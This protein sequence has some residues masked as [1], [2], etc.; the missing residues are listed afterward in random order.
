MKS[1]VL[2]AVMALWIVGCGSSKKGPPPSPKIKDAAVQLESS[3]ELDP[4]ANPNAVRGGRFTTWAGAFPKSL[5]QWLDYNSFSKSICDLMFEP[6]ADFHSAKNEPVGVLA[7]KWDVSED[8]LTFTFHIHPKARWSDG[9]PV[10][11]DD[12]LF[13]YETIMNP[14]HLTSL[15]RV[16]LSKLEKPEVL[17]E[18]RIRVKAK[19]AHWMNFWMVAELT[20]LPRHIWEG[21]DFNTLNFDM[22]VVSGP[23]ELS[24]VNKGR[25]VTLRRRGD[26]WGRAKRYNQGKYNFDELHFKSVNDRLKALEHFK[27]GELDLY[28]IYTAKI[29]AKQTDFDSVQKNWV[30]RQRVFT[31]KAQGFQ[32]LAINMRRPLFQDLR[33]RQAL[34][35][36]L[37]RDLM[38]EKFMYKEYF[39]LNS[40][41]P[42]LHPDFKNP[43]SI[44]YQ[45]NEEKAR[46]LLAEAGWKPG[47]DGVLQKDG[48][49]FVIQM[50]FFSPDTRHLS[51]F[52]EHLKRVGIVL[53][54]QQSTYSTIRKRLDQHDFD[55]H[56]TNWGSARLRNPETMWH[57]DTADNIA[58]QNLAGVKDPL[59]DSLIESQRLE[60]DAQKREEILKKIDTRLA[61][62]IPYALLW[63][64]PSYRLLYWNRFGMPDKVFS[65]FEDEEDAM[66]YWFVD[67]NKEK[68]LGEARAKGEAL[69][70]VP[71]VVTSKP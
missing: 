10:T 57:S 52:K 22:P 71:K 18:R 67:P 50:M 39:M 66:T 70:P 26:W 43:N 45:A 51:L 64:N 24:K 54:L 15:F 37:D 44:H 29:W 63:S 61:E 53:E 40:Y 14:K 28:P 20:A 60:K 68:A 49:P 16:S 6:L 8:G 31:Q 23:Y 5:N 48:Q 4:S 3:G 17:D 62:I 58:T 59:I 33:V 56:W 27:K 35:Y 11:A 38:N 7:E 36:M 30:V 65:P 34:C 32:G 25:S 13:Y 41:Y 55:L 19:T 21:K 2:G 47:E 12:V 9:K 1:L 46:E 42:D 69:P